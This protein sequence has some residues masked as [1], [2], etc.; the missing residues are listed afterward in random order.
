MHMKQ[1]FTIV[2][3]FI[4]VSLLAQGSNSMLKINIEGLRNIKGKLSVTLYNSADGFPEDTEKSFAW[5]SVEISDDEM[6]IYFNDIPKGKYAFAVLHDENEDGEM[7]KNLIGIPK[8]GFAFSEN[9][10]P[11]ISK[12][13]FND[14]MFEV[15]EGVNVKRIEMIYY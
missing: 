1:V 5:R 15:K 10:K 2:L 7:D 14:A 3:L 9:Y 12:P 6:S 8:E 11:K 13:S 4:S